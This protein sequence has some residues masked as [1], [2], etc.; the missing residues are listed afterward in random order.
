MIKST[1]VNQLVIL[2]FLLIT[3]ISCKNQQ[4]ISQLDS[5]APIEQEAEEAVTEEVENTDVPERKVVESP[6]TEQK[7]NNYFG[8]IA[9]ANSTDDAN[10]VIA[11][12]MTLFANPNAPVLIVFYEAN[13]EPSYDEPTTIMKYM[14]YLKDTKNYNTRVDEMVMDENGKIKELVLKKK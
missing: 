6:S 3:T 13:G 7:L 5:T 12:A 1:F 11:R 8:S 10:S 9:N 14:N 4:K 2:S